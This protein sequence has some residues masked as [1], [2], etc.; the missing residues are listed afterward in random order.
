M[1]EVRTHP[2]VASRLSSPPPKTYEE[3]LF[4]LT[5]LPPNKVF[6]MIKADA[7]PCGYSQLTLKEEK[8]DLGWAIHPAW[9]GQ[10]IGT[11]SVKLLIEYVNKK[12]PDK[13]ICLYVKK[14]NLAAIHVYKKSGFVIESSDTLKN[15]HSMRLQ[16]LD[17]RV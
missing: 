4:Y 16:D 10:S 14:D 17:P 11:N 5:H 2:D 3:H 9:W 7:M 12:Y 13:S 15:E 8:I 1:F 6:F